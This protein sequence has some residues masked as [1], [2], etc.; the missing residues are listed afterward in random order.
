MNLLG[1]PGKDTPK[2][3]AA[4]IRSSCGPDAVEQSQAS[5]RKRGGAKKGTANSWPHAQKM[6]SSV[7]HFSAIDQERGSMPFT[8]REDGSWTVI[9]RLRFAVHEKLE[10]REGKYRLHTVFNKVF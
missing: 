6:R 2:L 9:V 7:S 1:H 8:E 3:I 4:W 5:R 10:R